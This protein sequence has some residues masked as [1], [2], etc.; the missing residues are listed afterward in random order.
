MLAFASVGLAMEKAKPGDLFSFLEQSGGKFQE[1][2]TGADSLALAIANVG[3]NMINTKQAMTD[4]IAK[5]TEHATASLQLQGV[6]STM[7]QTLS[8]LQTLMAGMSTSEQDWIT[9]TQ[10]SIAA[11]NKHRTSL[12][13]LIGAMDMH[14]ASLDQSTTMLELEARAALGDAQAIKQLSEARKKDTAAAIA[15]N[16]VIGLKVKGY[17][18]GNIVNGPR[19]TTFRNGKIIGYGPGTAPP[20][21]TPGVGYATKQHGYQSTVHRPT[22]FIAG[23]GGRPEDVTVRPRGSVQRGGSGGSGGSSHV[24]I[25]FL[26]H[27]FTQFMRYRINDNQGVVK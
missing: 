23:E 3:N 11:E 8:P 9:K 20:Q 2:S 21:R 16:R 17:K 26:P 5:V 25:E 7:G 12:V 13:A 6:F 27:E 15:N 24:T 14:G 18:P 1:A 4:S 19:Y 22:M 10:V